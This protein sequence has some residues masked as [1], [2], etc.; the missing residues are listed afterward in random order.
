[1]KIFS[2]FIKFHINIFC[3][4]IK[5]NKNIKQYVF[6]VALRDEVIDYIENKYY[7]EYEHIKKSIAVLKMKLG[8]RKKIT[9]YCRYLL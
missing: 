8:D 6:S 4:L 3:S 7:S 9:N 5:K 2:T 1:M